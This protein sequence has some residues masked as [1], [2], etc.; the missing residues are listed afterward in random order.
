MKRTQFLC[1]WGSSSAMLQWYL[2]IGRESFLLELVAPHGGSVGSSMVEK[3]D[4]HI[5]IYG[6]VISV[7]TEISTSCY[8]TTENSQ[9][10]E[11]IRKI[12]GRN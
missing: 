7:N 6:N 8:G 10:T 3:V 12:C 11:E 1:W 5:L 9:P 2:R 4:K